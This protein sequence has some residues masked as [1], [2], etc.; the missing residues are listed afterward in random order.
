MDS[1]PSSSSYETVVTPQQE[2]GAG[3]ALSQSSTD[4]HRPN[5]TATPTTVEPLETNADF[6]VLKEY[7]KELHVSGE[8]G[9]VM[10]EGKL[11][12]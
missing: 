10:E 7:V 5:H 9:V 1:D 3:L 12:M 4:G 8:E 11:I 6:I 2:T